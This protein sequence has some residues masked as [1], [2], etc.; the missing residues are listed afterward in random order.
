[1][2][3]ALAR[4][5]PV[6]P[7]GPSL[8][9]SPSPVSDELDA[10]VKAR[11]T[12][13]LQALPP[14]LLQ[15]VFQHLSA[16]SAQLR[17]RLVC[18]AFRDAHDAQLVAHGTSHMLMRIDIAQGDSATGR[19]AWAK[20]MLR[21]AK[22]LQLKLSNDAAALLV[23]QQITRALV[24]LIKEGSPALHTLEVQLPQSIVL[25]ALQLAQLGSWCVVPRLGSMHTCCTFQ[26]MVR[27]MTQ[28]L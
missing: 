24:Q 14:E 7:L 10:H 20:K 22:R 16:G 19:S 28:I 12:T 5:P 27:C 2:L 8:F 9:R 21:A 17:M 4:S 25:G 13:M 18:K 6:W 15:A 23:N 3:D 26:H 1:M 11:V